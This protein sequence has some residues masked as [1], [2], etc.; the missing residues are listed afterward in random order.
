MGQKGRD[1]TKEWVAKQ[2][3]KAV[4]DAFKITMAKIER[5]KK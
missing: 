4:E 3:Q 2:V 1:R 5:K